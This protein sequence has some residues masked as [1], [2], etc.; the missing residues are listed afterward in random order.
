MVPQENKQVILL[1]QTIATNATTSAMI[2]R[3]G[4]DYASIEVVMP[5]ATATNSSAKWTVLKLTEADTTSV[6][7]TGI[8]GF[9]GTTNSTAATGTAAEFVIA[10]N[11]VTAVGGTT[12][13]NGGGQV[14]RMNLSLVGRKRYLFLIIQANASHQTAFAQAHLYRGAEMPDSASEANVA[15]LANN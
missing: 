13:A 2:D 8:A 14:T 9:I 5:P 10:A 6:S 12:A 15:V 1:N 7:S 4:F 3:L 11:N